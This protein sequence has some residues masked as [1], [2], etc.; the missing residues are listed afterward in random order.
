LTLL[1]FS[2]SIATKRSVQIF[3]FQLRLMVVDPILFRKTRE[4]NI[5]YVG[6]SM[7]LQY[8]IDKIHLLIRGKQPVFTIVVISVK[9]RLQLLLLRVGVLHDTLKVIV[10]VEDY[11]LFCYCSSMRL[12]RTNK[13]NQIHL[14]SA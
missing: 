2:G 9:S 11:K 4:K 12:K 7:S 10:L 6:F 13:R 8:L 3:F 14:C 5:L 1:G